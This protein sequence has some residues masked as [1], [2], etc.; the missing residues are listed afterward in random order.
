LTNGAKANIR[1]FEKRTP[2][3]MMDEDAT[4]EM[5]QLLI[6]YG[7]KSNLLD[8]QKNTILHHY[9]ENG[10]NKELVQQA[11]NF[12]VSV[13]AV[14]KEGKTALMIAVEND[15]SDI[16]EAL[17][18]SGADVNRPDRAGRPRHET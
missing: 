9:A 1:D 18:Q 8:K 2:L 4:P 10:D 16:A 15:E 3:M 11:V 14:N 5:F 6:R 17:I 13:N 12:G 7:A